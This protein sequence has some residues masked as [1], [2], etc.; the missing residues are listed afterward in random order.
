MRNIGD[1]QYADGDQDSSE[2]DAEEREQKKREKRAEKVRKKADRAAA[3][4]LGPTAEADTEIVSVRLDY[5]TAHSGVWSYANLEFTP[6]RRVSANFIIPTSGASF[7]V[8]GTRIEYAYIIQDSLG[9]TLT[10]DKSVV[11]YTDNR[12]SWEEAQVGPLTL[13]YHDIP[14]T[15]VDGLVAALSL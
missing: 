11:E 7:L 13:L 10:T 8:P 12:F 2:T 9:N 15:Q 6:D 14:R 5:R 1:E 3:K 4:K